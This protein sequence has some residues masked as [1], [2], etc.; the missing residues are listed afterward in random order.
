M[1][2][3]A[4]AE[5]DTKEKTDKEKTSETSAET[6]PETAPVS[7][8]KKKG[9]HKKG[10]RDYSQWA[11]A[12]A[13]KENKQTFLTEGEDGGVGAAGRRGG[14][15]RRAGRGIRR[16]FGFVRPPPCAHDA[17]R[18]ARVRVRG[19]DGE[20]TARVPARGSHGAEE[21]R[22]GASR[23]GNGR[24]DEVVGVE[25]RRSVFRRRAIDRRKSP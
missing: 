9:K 13:V 24:R 3:E 14:R 12:A 10:K 25:T 2:E 20:A 4:E 15:G 18:D 19:R 17:G 6:G 16:A 23:A 8:S 1:E 11:S 21:N 7:A 22:S 5:A